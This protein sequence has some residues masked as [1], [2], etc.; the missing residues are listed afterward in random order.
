MKTITRMALFGASLVAAGSLFAI[1]SSKPLA[2]DGALV[3]AGDVKLAAGGSQVRVQY[4]HQAAT[5][6]FVAYYSNASQ[7]RLKV[8]AIN[9][10]DPVAARVREYYVAELLGV[11]FSNPIVFDVD[12]DVSRLNLISILEKFKLQ[13]Q[14]SGR[15][16]KSMLDRKSSADA[17][18]S[19]A[20]T[21]LVELKADAATSTDLI[22]AQQALIAGLK[23]EITIA[24]EVSAL[25][26]ISSEVGRAKIHMDHGVYPFVATFEPGQ[27]QLY[28]LKAGYNVQ[29]T[30]V[31]A[32]FYVDLIKRA[33]ELKQRL[34]DGELRER[35][36]RGEL[37]TLFSA[38]SN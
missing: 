17:K 32:D 33:P 13:A 27:K 22:A 29:M 21:K 11:G 6:S 23:E 37:E 1:E 20:E 25:K 31:H 7:A 16:V 19:A 8:S 18:L 24:E 10:F 26:V 12:D 3:P 15:L 2:S 36:L 34:L 38:E 35:K 28:V 30:D 5:R 4:E 14:K 9:R